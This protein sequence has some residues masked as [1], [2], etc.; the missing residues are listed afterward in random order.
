VARRIMVAG[1]FKR[2]GIGGQARGSLYCQ[3][4]LRIQRLAQFSSRV[5]KMMMITR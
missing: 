3:V 5:T 4:Y 2:E 1:L